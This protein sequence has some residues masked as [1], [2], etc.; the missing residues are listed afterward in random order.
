MKIKFYLLVVI[1]II[2]T[3]A[4]PCLSLDYSKEDTVKIIRDNWGIPHIAADNEKAL[5]YGAGY[6]AAEDR[7][8]QMTL[9]R[10][11]IQGRLAEILGTRY[12]DR[13]KRVR[14]VGY[15]SHAKRSFSQ[16]DQN[17]QLL[18][19]AY[20]DGVNA[21]MKDH[22]EHLKEL[23]DKYGGPPEPWKPEDGVACFLRIAERFDGGW[24]NEV[25]VLRNY[26]QL[27]QS[28]GRDSALKLLEMQRNLVDDE[29]AIVSKE[30]FEK[31]E[32]KVQNLNTGIIDLKRNKKDEIQS[33][34]EAP[35]MS[36]NWVVGGSKSTT[37]LPILESDPQIAVESPSTW[38]EFHLHGGR[39]NVRGI[40]VPGTPAMLI[41]YNEY[42][43]WGMTALGSDNADLFEEKV[44]PENENQYKWK[45]EWRTFNKHIENI[46]VKD[47]R[48][49]NYE[50]RSTHHGPVV[51]DFLN[52]VNDSEVFSLN[53][54]G[55]NFPATDVEGL[56]DMMAA[57]DWHEFVNGMRKYRSPGVH[58]IYADKYNNIGYYTLSR[59]P[60]RVHNA[61][62]PFN[63]WNGEEEWQGIIPFDSMP[64]MIN[65]YAGFIST[66]N[67]APIGSWYPFNVG[68]G[69]GDNARSWRLREILT[70]KEKW[71][72]EEFFDIH[73][74]A[75]NP[76]V[77]DFA[78]FGL[79]AVDEENP[80]DEDILAAAE[81]L[82]DWD[83]QLLTSYDGYKIVSIAG[84]VIKRS[85]RGTPLE[86]R[87]F[88]SNAGLAQLFRDV[89]AHYD[90]TGQLTPDQ[91]IRNW[92]LDQLG[93][94]YRQSGIE[95]NPRP[96]TV[97]HNML[98]QNN[99][100]GYGTLHRMY[101]QTSPPLHCGVV[102]TIW[103][104]L[105]NSYSQLVNYANVD[106]SFTVLPPGNSEVHDDKHFNSQ[107]DLWVDGDMHI[108]PLSLDGA[109]AIK[110]SEYILRPGVTGIL[111]IPS[112]NPVI[113][114]YPNPFREHLNIKLNQNTAKPAVIKIFDFNGK[115][116]KVAYSSA[117]NEGSIY[118][119]DGTDKS[120]H[121]VPSGLYIIQID[122]GDK[123]FEF[124]A[125]K[126]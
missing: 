118:K 12:V 27:A 84:S 93:E 5:F 1:I 103:S 19:E 8:F 23:F 120:G 83:Y 44:N 102:A 59:L 67:N 36:H 116:I 85:L 26:E 117:L 34:W 125:L 6:A 77:R 113:E 18:L 79:M 89:Q 42:C 112:D 65:P 122:L 82:R 119:W 123:Q 31:Y 97:T 15:Y 74:D 66:A 105:G 61:G 73:T 121:S 71:S 38:Y 13:D 62:I 14:T 94:V 3:A 91:D 109:N 2:I 126:N 98:Y 124:K 41:G 16:L 63:G 64:R 54:I 110:E 49:I 20:A 43:A 11:S 80:T 29:V 68:G 81:I 50:V 48:D 114:I 107:I 35:K 33:D 55:T 108:A 21:Y 60:Q 32:E 53:Y 106:S 75:I 40:S 111:E 45:D 4:L 86:D 47:N 56:L 95:S 92:L 7:L 100:E 78:K 30:E 76:I 17:I 10:Y 57:T 72:P 9:A 70:S 25:N 52:K 24:T 39:F 28:V 22:P 104:Q 58:L 69:I 51:N 99:L 101:D 87:Y 46:K 88:G 96:V 115:L 37:G 90:S